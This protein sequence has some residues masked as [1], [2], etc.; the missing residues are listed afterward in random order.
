MADRGRVRTW[1]SSTGSNTRV[2]VGAGSL[3]AI[4]GYI[5]AGGT[6]VAENSLNLGANPNLNG[7]S[8][9]NTTMAWYGPTAAAGTFS[10][11]YGPGA[12]FDDGL[13]VAATSN[14]RFT[15]TYE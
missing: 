5:P 14:A 13:V 3:Y 7:S 1:S 12:G 2:K 15:V 9:S 6:I 11:T 10:V 8:T 4:H